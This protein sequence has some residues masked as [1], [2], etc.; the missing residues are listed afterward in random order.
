M[1]LRVALAFVFATTADLG[2]GLEH[3]FHNRFIETCSLYSSI[4]CTRDSPYRQITGRKAYVCAVQIHMD[5]VAQLLEPIFAKAG[6]G[7]GPACVS[8]IEAYIRGQNQNIKNI[9]G[10][11]VNPGVGT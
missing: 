1:V 4:P 3:H 2:T 6:I 9:V 8:A 5:T 7:A 10:L 11:S